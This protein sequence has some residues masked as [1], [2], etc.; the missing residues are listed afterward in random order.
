MRSG[1]VRE[2]SDT[3]PIPVC[4]YYEILFVTIR[5]EIIQYLRKMYR[6]RKIYEKMAKNPPCKTC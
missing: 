6:R 4:Y 2:A 1:F 3:L 5:F